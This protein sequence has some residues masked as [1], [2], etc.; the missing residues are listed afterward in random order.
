VAGLAFLAALILHPLFLLPVFAALGLW[1]FVVSFFRD[2]ERII[3]SDPAALLSPADGTITHIDHVE[4]PDFPGGRAFR[5]S[6]FL[7]VFN[8]HVNRLPRSARVVGLH[9]YPGTFLYANHPDCF[10]RNEQLWIDLDDGGR[11]V[12]VKQISGVAARRIVCWLKVGD[13]VPAGERFGMI[14]FGSRTEVYLPVGEVEE[15]L[16]KVGD[17]VGGG[18]SVL[19]RLRQPAR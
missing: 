1:V 13:V 19:A 16:V 4:D 2:P 14:K 9:Y 8:V 3:P 12:R 5:I 10:A 18:S 15:V 11:F 7:S 6:M 17:R